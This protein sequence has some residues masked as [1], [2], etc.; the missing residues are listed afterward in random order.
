MIMGIS[1]VPQ[2]IRWILED[3]TLDLHG[4]VRFFF[5]GIPRMFPDNQ[6]SHMNLHKKSFTSTNYI[7]SAYHDEYN[8]LIDELPRIKR[9]FL[10][11]YVYFVSYTRIE[12]VESIRSSYHI[13]F[14]IVD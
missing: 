8:R 7:T 4:A 2:E 11:S 3:I 12:Y 9:Y 5:C 13:S 1:S 6:K 14:V 10:S